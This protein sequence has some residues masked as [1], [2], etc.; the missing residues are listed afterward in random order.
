MNQVYAFRKSHVKALTAHAEALYVLSQLHVLGGNIPKA[1][2]NAELSLEC[3]YIQNFVKREIDY[4]SNPF[5][6]SLFFSIRTSPR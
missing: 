1:K 4:F 6:F 2:D 5:A 3:K